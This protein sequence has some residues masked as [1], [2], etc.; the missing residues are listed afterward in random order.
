MLL[1]SLVYSTTVVGDYFLLFLF[2][3]IT[4][5]ELVRVSFVCLFVC[6]FFVHS[7]GVRFNYDDDDSKYRATN[8]FLIRCF[9]FIFFFS[10]YLR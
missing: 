10:R 3:F 1:V 6:L 5:L 7:N 8:V 9:L 2:L 4:S